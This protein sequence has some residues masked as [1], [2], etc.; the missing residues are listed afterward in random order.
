VFDKVV[1]INRER[2]AQTRIREMKGFGF[3][4]KFHIAYV[5]M[6]EFSRAAAV[7]PIV[8]VED[9]DQDAFRPV[10]LLGL[11][12]GENLFVGADGRWDASYVPA[13]IRRYPFALTASGSEGEFTICID[14][15]S[16]RVSD[17][18]GSRL[19]DDQGEPT[20][21]IDNVKRYLSELQQMDQLTQQFSAWLKENNMLTPLNMRVRDHDEVKNI[22]GCY[23]V[24]EERL[25]NLSDARYLELRARRFLPALYAQ[26]I[27]LPQVERLV[28]LKDRRVAG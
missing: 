24:N 14:E 15:A 9:K 19:F 4:S 23:V 17:T 2:H 26:L 21:V 3:A 20:A 8:F 5:T 25:N 6:H 16:E 22:A 28:S 7:Y 18:D 11:D 1:P 12:A 13:I 27:S 10:V